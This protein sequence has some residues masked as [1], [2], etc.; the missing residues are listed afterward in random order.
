MSVLVNMAWYN[1]MGC[2]DDHVAWFDAYAI[3]ERAKEN[4]DTDPIDLKIAH[5]KRVLQNTQQIVEEENFPSFLHRACLL[6]AL[7]HDVARF[8]QYL[9][10]RTFRDRESVDHG[11]FGVAILKR[12]QCLRQEPKE[13]SRLV[14]VAVC[15]H[16][17]YA[18]PQKLPDDVG[19]VCQV[20][21]DA[22]KLDVLNI[23]DKHLSGSKPYNPTVILNLPDKPDLGNPDIVQAVLQNRIA[24]YADLRNVDDFRLLLGTWF[25]DMH[26][27]ASRQKFVADGH[28]KRIIEGIPDSPKYS[29]PKAYLLS[30]LQN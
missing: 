17:R 16:N 23:M 18:L 25:H 28:A 3:Q 2:I 24:A 4:E 22:D 10:Y 1:D 19:L 26:F 30:L 11:K 5:T 29:K 8:E 9:R 13:I 12:E 20:I 7:Y 6:A 15:L 14:L 27:A 21:R